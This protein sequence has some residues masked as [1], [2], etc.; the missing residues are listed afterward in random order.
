MLFPF[1]GLE[2]DSELNG[3][4]SGSRDQLMKKCTSWFQEPVISCIVLFRSAVEI[5]CGKGRAPLYRGIMGLC[6]VSAAADQSSLFTQQRPP[7]PNLAWLTE[8]VWNM[9]CDLEVSQ[10]HLEETGGEGRGGGRV[11]AGGTSR[12]LMPSVRFAA[13]RLLCC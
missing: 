2:N 3:T 11:K 12:V 4:E 10:Q 9:C 5:W 8:Q 6:H 7:K 1:I 13:F